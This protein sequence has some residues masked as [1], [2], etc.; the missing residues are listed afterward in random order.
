MKQVSR[1]HPLLVTLHWVLAALIIAML[2]V[3]FFMLAAM[4]NSNPQKIT[5]L[6]WHMS[7][8][9]LILALMTIRFIIRMRTLRPIAATT[10]FS[11]LDR[12]A[13][14][15]H[16]SFYVLVVLMAG[17]GLATAIWPNLTRSCFRRRATRC[18]KASGFIQP[19]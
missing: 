11:L 8:G 5:V 4:P 3:G 7:G 10:G 14:F 6:M 13:P 1:Y 19:L 2:S 15:T 12:I 18:R 9:M 17:T 16:Y